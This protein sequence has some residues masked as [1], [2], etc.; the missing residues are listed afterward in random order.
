MLNSETCAKNCTYSWKFR[1]HIHGFQQLI[2]PSKL[3]S[4]NID[5]KIKLSARFL[6][7]RVYQNEGNVGG[8]RNKKRPDERLNITG[9][10]P[11]QA[12]SA[13]I[14][15]G[16]KTHRCVQAAKKILKTNWFSI[17]HEKSVQ[18][19]CDLVSSSTGDLGSSSS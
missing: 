8:K 6:Q 7:P 10:K 3:H 19:F 18:G 15:Q 9:S 12:T 2:K 13:R 5:K 1:L 4:G 17:T 16:Q 11:L 14:F